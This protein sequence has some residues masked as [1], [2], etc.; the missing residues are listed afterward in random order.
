MYVCMYVCII[1]G[2]KAKENRK[3]WYV[4]MCV[5]INKQTTKILKFFSPPP[6]KRK[7]QI[8][9]PIPINKHSENG[10]KKTP[11][12]IVFFF[13][14]GEWG[15]GQVS[16]LTMVTHKKKQKKK[17]S[18]PFFFFFFFIFKFSLNYHRGPRVGCRFAV[19][20][21]VRST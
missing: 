8:F 2:F 4:H 12:R 1:A 10:I 19:R 9:P 21:Y 15:G 18:S 13:W 14:E 3:L 16:A 5:E 6:P 17:L 20:Q 7:G 11:P